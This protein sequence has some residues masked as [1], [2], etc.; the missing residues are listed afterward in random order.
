M[1]ADEFEFVT[2]YPLTVEKTGTG[3][4]IIMSTPS[5]IDCGSNCEA[6]FTS[7]TV[8]TLTATPLEGST[9]SGWSG[10][11]SGTGDC[12]VTISQVR[13]VTASFQ[14]VSP[15][16]VNLTPYRPSGW[17]D[18]IVVANTMDTTMDS[19]TLLTTDS[20]FIDWAVINDGSSGINTSFFTAL[21]IDGTLEQTWT[22]DSLESEHYAYVKDHTIGNLSP[23]SH[24]IEILTDT[25][26]SID[27]TNELD[28]CYSKSIM[29]TSAN[30]TLTVSASS[31]AVAVP[32]ATDPMDLDGVS[33]G[34]TSFSLTY[35]NGTEVALTAPATWDVLE[36]A[37]WIGCDTDEGT[38]CTVLMDSERTVTAEYAFP[39][40]DSDADGL[41][42]AF[43]NFYG[44]DTG[45]DD[46]V[47][48]FD[49]DGFCNLRE[50]R[51]DTNPA[52]RLDIPVIIAD[53]DLDSD[54]DGFDLQALVNEMGNSCTPAASCFYDCTGDCEVDEMDLRFFAEDMGRLE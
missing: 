7:G 1:G 5:G 27:E 16:E 3:N 11:C 41:P 2:N 8:V 53:H 21:F 48:D 15:D 49:D 25:T 46:G 28:N 54:V 30:H 32:I 44:I 24:L 37:G 23:G 50:Y 35:P 18:K 6:Y 33:S 10:A 4:G 17:S 47:A 43:E 31:P 13:E 26:H 39:P 51:D 9:F 36:F 52:D 22:T 40:E 29:I 19:S 12:Q 38:T 42:D 14:H 45:G 34:E 20:L